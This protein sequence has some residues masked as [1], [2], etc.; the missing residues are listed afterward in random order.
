[1][2][3]NI[4]QLKTIKL[5]HFNG[6]LIDLM[7]AENLAAEYDDASVNYDDATQTLTLTGDEEFIYIVL[8][9]SDNGIQS[10]RAAFAA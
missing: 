4:T 9:Q 5:T 8:D 1:M 2:D 3:K 6:G 10:F 7:E